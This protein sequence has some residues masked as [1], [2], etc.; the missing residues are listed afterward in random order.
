MPAFILDTINLV[1]DM[2]IP[3]AMIIAGSIVSTIDLKRF[4]TD[5]KSLMVSFLRLIVLPGI[6]F[7]FVYA[8]KMM[9]PMMKETASVIVMMTAMP[10]G[11]I[12][13]LVAERENTAPKFAARTVIMSLVFMIVTLPLFAYLC[14][15]FF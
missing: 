1:G 14:N 10:C 2:T 3:L 13:V 7:I 9:I 11:I 12:N 15:R 8:V 6:M 4:F 5:R